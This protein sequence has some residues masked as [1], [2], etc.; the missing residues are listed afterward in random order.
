[1][2]MN[3]YI[4]FITGIS[5]YQVFLFKHWA[6]MKIYIFSENLKNSHGKLLK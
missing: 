4:L 6:E 3:V 2:S 1:M 5:L